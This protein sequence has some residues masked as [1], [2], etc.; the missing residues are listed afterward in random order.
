MKILKKLFVTFLCFALLFGCVP[1]LGAAKQNKSFDSAETMKLNSSVEEYTSDL[2]GGGTYA[3]A[4]YKITVP[5]KG[6]L[7]IHVS[8]KCTAK[9]NSY[10]LTNT[11]YTSKQNVIETKRTEVSSPLINEVRTVTLSQELNPG[12][13]YYFFK[14]ASSGYL[15]IPVYKIKF[16]N[17]FRCLHTNT[18]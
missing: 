18:T 16:T 7:A 13:Y 5:Y 10:A 3:Y 14:I 2:Y 6:S 1:V 11:L 17:S 12:T 8:M 9:G 15:N 4:Y